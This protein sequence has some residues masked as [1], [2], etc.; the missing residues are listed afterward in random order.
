MK[1]NIAITFVLGL[2]AFLVVPAQAQFGGWA[3]K[4]AS[5]SQKVA[6]ANK[7]WSPEQ[8]EAIG[9]AAAGKLVHIFG[10]YKNPDM[11]LYVNLVG[12]TVAQYGARPVHYHFA[13]LDT[14]VANAFAMPGGYIFVTRGALQKMKNESELAGVLAHEV[15][16]IDGRHLERDLRQKQTTGVL[17][18]AGVEEGTSHVPTGYVLN[19]IAT[20]VITAALTQQVSPEKENEADRNG[21]SFA[22]R[23]GY[24]PYGLRNFLQTLQAA[25]ADANYQRSTNMMNGKTH[26]P[27][28]DRIDKLTKQA[29][30]LPA[31]GQKLDKRFAEN[32]DFKA[33]TANN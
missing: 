5:K 9:R 33:K 21:T 29:A 23:A 8:E 12:N 4:I 15:S 10:V 17:V 22:Q 32:V 26:P 7:E 18:Q 30:A 24:D 16:H 20:K 27:F 2:A 25:S 19:Q 13:I 14:D 1:E 3:G 11:L 31:G 28:P 6:E